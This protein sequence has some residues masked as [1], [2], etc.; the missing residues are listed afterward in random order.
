M[1]DLRLIFAALCVAVLGAGAA[2]SQAVNATL[3]GTVTDVSGAVVPNA[4]VTIAET[5]TGVVRTAQTNESG[6]WT[7][8][9]LPPGVYA[10]SIEA[11][12]FKRE[13]RR[14]I[15]LLV[16]TTTRVDTQ[17]T[18]GSISETVEVTGAPALLQTD[19]AAT[20][21]EIE[22]TVLANAP[23]ISANRNFQSL[24]TLAPGVAPVQEQHSQFFNASSSLQT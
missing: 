18:P 16:D 4:K 2:W 17:L 22:R 12:G 10:V 21:E 19:T 9:D 13:T 11:S 14:D 23:L 20:G 5:Q 15:T 7:V 8:S 3:L 1:K 24:L 6:N